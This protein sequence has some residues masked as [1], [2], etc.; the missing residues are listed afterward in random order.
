[1]LAPSPPTAE[2]IPEDER[3]RL[4]SAH[5]NRCVATETVCRAA[6]GKLSAE[7]FE[8]AVTDNLRSSQKAW[9]AWLESESRRD[10]SSDIRQ[11]NVPV[12][13]AAGE[14]DENMTAKLLK[15]EIV[16]RIENARLVVV[17]EVKHLLPLEAPEEIAD[18]IR[19]QVENP[20]CAKADFQLSKVERNI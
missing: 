12:L 8:R 16:R 7:I 13:V 14:A 3:K 2:P 6:G 18:L 15:R 11:I 19:R 17:P 5:G 4:L 10:V 20:S 1:L 9:R